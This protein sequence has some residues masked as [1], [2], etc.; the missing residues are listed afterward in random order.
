VKNK[1]TVQETE[2]SIIKN[3]YISLIDMV[4]NIIEFLSVWEKIDL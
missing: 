3:D 1:I 2:V 4:R